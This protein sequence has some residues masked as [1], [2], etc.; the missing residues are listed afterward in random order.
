MVSYPCW[1]VDYYL[2][3]VVLH[4][5]ISC[6]YH[7]VCVFSGCCCPSVVLV[8]TCFYLLLLVVTL[9]RGCSGVYRFYF[10]LSITTA[11]SGTIKVTHPR[12]LNTTA[13]SGTIVVSHPR[14]LLLLSRE[15]SK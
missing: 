2:V 7:V 15:R 12:A 13:E 9:D 4:T 10:P 8:V 1:F 5:I 3:L 6:L 11:E 14:A